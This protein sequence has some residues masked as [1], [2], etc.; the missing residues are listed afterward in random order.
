[1]AQSWLEL[2]WSD[3]PS[4]PDELR[5]YTR[6]H[7]WNAVNLGVM[8]ALTLVLAFLPP[9]NAW[10]IALAVGIT[11]LAIFNAVST[12]RRI[13]RARRRVLAQGV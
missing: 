8:A 2:A 9:A 11:L 7:K 5:T 10:K 12:R 6:M 13:E 4:T 3:Q 1:M